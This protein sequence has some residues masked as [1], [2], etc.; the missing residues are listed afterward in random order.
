MWFDLFTAN[1]EA[2]D[3]KR[4]LRPC[5]NCRLSTAAKTAQPSDFSQVAQPVADP[6]SGCQLF[7]GLGRS[8]PVDHLRPIVD[9]QVTESGFRDIGGNIYSLDPISVKPSSGHQDQDNH[10]D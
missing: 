4:K 7:A 6:I 5:E 1:L 9:L 3:D 2:H 8:Q 10:R